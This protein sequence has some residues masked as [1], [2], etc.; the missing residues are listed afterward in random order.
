MCLFHDI[1][2]KMDKYP[3]LPKKECKE[4]KKIFTFNKNFIIL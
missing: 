2:N 4:Y 1:D 3:R